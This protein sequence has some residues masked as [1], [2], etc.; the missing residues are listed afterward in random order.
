MAMQFKTNKISGNQE[1]SVILNE[2]LKLV[3]STQ[4]TC[5]KSNFTV[6]FLKID[7]K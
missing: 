6:T 2:N 1:E 4:S 7:K 3:P 5:W